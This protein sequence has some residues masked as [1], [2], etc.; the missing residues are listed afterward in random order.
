[1]KNK[2]RYTSPA[3]EWSLLRAEDICSL[4]DLGTGDDESVDFRGWIKEE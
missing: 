2:Q 3:L 1:M 4:S